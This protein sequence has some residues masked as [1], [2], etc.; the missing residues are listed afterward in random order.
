MTSMKLLM[1]D[2]VSLSWGFHKIMPNL[3][4][5]NLAEVLTSSPQ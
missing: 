2:Y 4:G 1:F 5:G 3:V